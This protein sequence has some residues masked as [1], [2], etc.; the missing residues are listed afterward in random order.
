M[1]GFLVAL[2]H[3]LP[4]R[5]P[6][7][8]GCYILAMM[9][10][11]ASCGTLHQTQASITDEQNFPMSM[12]YFVVLLKENT[13]T[14][15]LHHHKYSIRAY[16]MHLSAGIHYLPIASYQVWGSLGPFWPRFIQPQ[17]ERLLSSGY[18]KH[19][20]SNSTEP[21]KASAVNNMS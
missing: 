13:T 3:T 1:T 18:I 17:W 15:N 6:F 7:H 4:H 2:L 5:R 14:S 11:F 19:M 10:H 12:F 16:S 8:F 20:H 21:R 9:N